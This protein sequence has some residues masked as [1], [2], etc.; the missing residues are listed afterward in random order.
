MA[1]IN[2]SVEVPDSLPVDFTAAVVYCHGYADQVRTADG[3]LMDNKETKEEAFKRIVCGFLKESY[4]SFCINAD[5]QK[6][7][8]EKAKEYDCIQVSAV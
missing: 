7:K 1:T 4:K 3:K 6:M 5:M 8:E 2:L